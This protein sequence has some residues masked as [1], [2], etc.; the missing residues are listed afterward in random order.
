MNDGLSLFGE[1]RIVSH[2]RDHF[3]LGAELA[4]A[5]ESCEAV[6]DIVSR[7]LVVNIGTSVFSR[8]LGGG[9][10]SPQVYHPSAPFGFSELADL[11][12][13]SMML[14]NTVSPHAPDPD[15]TTGPSTPIFTPNLTV[16]YPTW[17]SV[18][19]SGL[20][21][22]PEF[23]GTIFTEE[24]LLLRNG[25]LFAKTRFQRQKTAAFGLQFDHEIT[26]GR[27]P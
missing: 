16:T 15:D 22:Q 23:D 26:I 10:G 11:S 3:L 25:A 19:F 21:P 27:A 12:V 8:L 24:A 5:L 18:R 14:G 9:A 6:L 7:N 17:Y 13:A 1:L 2:R 20:V 4:D